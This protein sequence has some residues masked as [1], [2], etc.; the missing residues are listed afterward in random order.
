MGRIIFFAILTGILLTQLYAVLGRDIKHRS[1]STRKKDMRS[2]FKEKVNISTQETL[3]IMTNK[4]L[5]AFLKAYPAFNPETFLKGAEMAFTL[6][7]KAYISGD[8]THLKKLMTPELF[9][10]FDEV[11]TARK[12]RGEQMEN[13]LFDVHSA[14]LKKTSV[15]EEDLYASVEFVS[16]Q[17]FVLK[18]AQGAILA[19]SAELIKTATD[20]WVFTRKI[21]SQSSKWYLAETSPEDSS[22][23]KAHETSFL[24]S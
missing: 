14:T 21:A 23:K 11:L 22:Q 1:M 19:G 16:D 15:Q 2:F 20:V 13:T 9:K 18:D 8:R 5:T 17:C 3:P 4:S 7:Q 10:I 24:P 12:K 6:I